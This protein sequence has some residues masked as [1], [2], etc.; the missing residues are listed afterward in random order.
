MVASDQDGA[1]QA[2]PE[3]FVPHTIAAGLD[4]ELIRLGEGLSSQKG[5]QNPTKMGWSTACMPIPHLASPSVV[6]HDVVVVERGNAVGQGDRQCLG[7]ELDLRGD[8]DR[9]VARRGRL[10]LQ[11]IRSRA[12]EPSRSGVR[13]EE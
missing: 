9:P 1:S 8:A 12:D 2:D 4:R 11:Q 5:Q 13:R 6:E 10:K 7:V 3:A